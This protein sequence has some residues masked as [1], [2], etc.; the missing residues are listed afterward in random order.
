MEVG[1]LVRR[2]WSDQRMWLIRGISTCAFGTLD[3][4]LSQ[5]GASAA[6]F[7]L[8]SKAEEKEVNKLYCSGKFFFGTTSSLF[9][10]MGTIAIVNLSSFV[11]GFMK[12]VRR[13]GGVDE[14]F[15]QLLLCGF[16]VANSL[17][18]YEA[19]FF[20]KDVGKMSRSVIYASILLACALFCVGKM[21]S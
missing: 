19:M 5:I 12:A 9:I 11:F 2:W 13:V 6:G 1:G 21:I 4:V 14:M 17:P 8:T 18:V 20:R 10:S 16:V 15:L 3:F 7:N